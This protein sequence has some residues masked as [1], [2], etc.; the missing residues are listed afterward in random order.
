[1]ISE[2]ITSTK[3]I[4]LCDKFKIP[5]VKIK[6]GLDEKGKKTRKAYK[7]FVEG[8]DNMAIWHPFR[9]RVPILQTSQTQIPLQTI[10]F[11]VLL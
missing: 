4:D 3:T 9:T 10:R 5:Y 7:L 11:E 1:M 8:D 6:L 2:T